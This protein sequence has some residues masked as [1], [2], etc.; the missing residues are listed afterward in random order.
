MPGGISTEIMTVNESH[1]AALTIFAL[2]KPFRG[3]IE[4]IQRNA[5]RSW[6]EL[7]P[8]PE[9]LVFGDDA[10]TAE[11]AQEFGLR[12][13]PSIRRNEFGTPLVSDLFQQAQ[14]AAA[15]DTLCYVNSDIILLADF[16]LAVEGIVHFREKFLM[17]G[18]RL[19]IDLAEPLLF[20]ANGWEASL[21]SRA[22]ARGKMNIAR[23]IDYFVFPRSLYPPLPEMALGRFWWDN[24]L[25]WKAHA[26]GAAVVDATE[27]VL[28]IHQ[29]HE[30]SHY[31]GGRE[32][33]LAG[34]EAT[35][36]CR[37]GCE[38]N[39]AD[40][41]NGL[42]WRYFYTIDD[43]THVLARDGLKPT[44]RHTWKMVKRTLGNPRSLPALIRQTLVESR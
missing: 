6:I 17:V 8:T 16:P 40:F 34:E 3:H 43:A 22:L 28:A 1:S 35:R 26:L 36:N 33:M 25:I 30:Y 24:W 9:V 4:T 42:Y 12:Y 27:V 15:H 21:R 7:K 14:S 39:P 19:D 31:A 18:R 37:L 13:I 32:A 11:I 41:D 44:R 2:P 5:I 20:D 23:S 10:G 29:N 38:T